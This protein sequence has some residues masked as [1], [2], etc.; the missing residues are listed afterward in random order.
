MATAKFN[1]PLAIACIAVLL[2]GASALAILGGGAGGPPPPQVEQNELVPQKQLEQKQLVQKQPIEQ[3]RIAALPAKVPEPP[4]VPVGGFFVEGSKE[5]Q[6]DWCLIAELTPAG[7]EIAMDE[8][9][10]FHAQRG[11]FPAEGQL[12]Y[13]AANPDIIEDRGYSS[14]PNDTLVALGEQGD[15]RALAVLYHRP[16]IDI[17]QRARAFRTSLL[18]GGTGLISNYTAAGRLSVISDSVKMEYKHSLNEIYGIDTKDSDKDGDKDS[19]KA[20]IKRRYLDVLAIN[21]F[22]IKRGDPYARADVL[23]A[24]SPET[25]QISGWQF[26]Q[27]DL[28]YVEQKADRIYN[29]LNRRRASRGLAPFDDASPPPIIQVMSNANSALA[30]AS[31]DTLEGPW[32][33]TLFPKSD[34]TD[35]LLALS[36]AYRDLYDAYREEAKAAEGVGVYHS[37]TAPMAD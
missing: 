37:D 22:A 4:E 8:M 24:I 1:K 25:L 35:A 34:C 3:E 16:G 31:D 30:V 23:R 2:G 36:A 33:Q 7:R 10:E 21:F 5:Y 32:L 17:D 29:Q 15:L 9:A 13:S 12:I 18:H 27:E 28:R 6:D 14:Y 26:D 20:A 11:S 19:D